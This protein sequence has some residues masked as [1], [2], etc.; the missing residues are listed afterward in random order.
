MNRLRLIVGLSGA[1]GVIMGFRLLETLRRTAECETHLVVTESARRTWE[2]ETERDVSVLYAL[3]D[4]VYDPHDLSAP[5]S[6]GSYRTDGMIVLPCSMKTLAGIASGYA[7]N[8]L[9]RAADVCLKENRRLVICPRE[10]PLSRVHLRNL[11]E[12][13]QAGCTVLPPMLTFYNR[14]MTVDDQIDHV[15]GKVLAQ[16]GLVPETFR[17]WGS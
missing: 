17:A 12:A 11:Y 3:A 16:F 4:R 9:L 15:I 14:P 10:T 5:I 6:S 1:S 2:L 13:A 8:L 7:D